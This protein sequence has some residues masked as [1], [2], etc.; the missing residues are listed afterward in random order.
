[1]K[2]IKNRANH[3]SMKVKCSSCKSILEITINDVKH[4][5]DIFQ[6]FG[7][8][9]HID[10]FSFNCGACGS[11]QILDECNAEFKPEK[12]PIFVAKAAKGY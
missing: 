6:C 2:I 4:K 1:M 7:G 5:V 3:W 10:T 8:A 11:A 12:I 9:E